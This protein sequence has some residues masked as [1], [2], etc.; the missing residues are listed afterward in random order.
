MP[1]DTDADRV[2][3]SPDGK[4]LASGGRDSLVRILDARTLTVLETL[5]APIKSIYGLAFAPNGRFLV[6]G[7]P[8]ADS[9]V[10]SLVYSDPGKAKALGPTSGKP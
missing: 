3:F 10:W 5:P 1:G 7:G 9:Y 6:A 2:A 8:E 4:Y